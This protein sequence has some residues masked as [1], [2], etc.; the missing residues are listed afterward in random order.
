MAHRPNHFQATALNV[1][2]AG[3][4]GVAGGLLGGW[5]AFALLVGGNRN[6]RPLLNRLAESEE[7]RR[8]GP[9]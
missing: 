5:P 6:G 3:L 4:A 9:V 1:L 2:A 7:L 8:I